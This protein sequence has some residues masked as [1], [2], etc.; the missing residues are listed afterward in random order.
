MSEE[1]IFRTKTGFCHILPDKIVLTR[2]GIAGSAVNAVPGKTKS[3]GRT[4]IIYGLLTIYFAYKAF[5]MF[6]KGETVWAGLYFLVV[7]FNIYAIATSINNS[8][9]SVIERSKIKSVTFKNA[10]PG[11][12]RSYFEIYFEDENGKI[13]KRLIMLPGSLS[14][15]NNETQKAMQIMQEEGLLFK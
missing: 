10:Q 6:S 15:G 7:V 11:I 14:N 4:L 13:K 12:T 5:T 1:K 9:A 2:E 8:T 3:I